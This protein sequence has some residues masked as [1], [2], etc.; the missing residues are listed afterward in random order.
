MNTYTLKNLSEFSELDEQMI[1]LWNKKYKIFYEE[2]IDNKSLFNAKNLKKL[3]LVSF[4]IEANKRHT[5]ESLSPKQL[6]E[7]QVLAEFETQ[8]YINKNKD[9]QILIQLLIC[10]CFSY[11]AKSFDSI[12]SVC[13][14]K[15]GIEK[16][17]IEVVFP[18]L[19]KMSVILEKYTIQE[20]VISFSTN[21]IRK[22][23]FY[24]IKSIPYGENC[25]RK[26]L[27]FLPENET[28][29]LELLYSYLFLK[30]NNEKSIYLG[31]NQSLES[32][33]EC[34]ENVSITHTVIYISKGFD[35]TSVSNYLILL[36]KLN[37]TMTIFVTS[38]NPLKD[39]ITEDIEYI[40]INNPQTFNTYLQ[41]IISM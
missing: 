9:Y 4:L 30:M 41:K 14:N 19:S 31:E 23:L 11:D 10:S 26:W 13:F 18:F 3:I 32:V 39:K 34:L 35:C 17:C 40:N 2:K 28:H 5:V 25:K 33:T 21:L 38:Y 15:I 24:L 27:L 8:N 20:S 7:L 6:V 1:I 12:L 36:K 16:C 29:D 22:H 37:P